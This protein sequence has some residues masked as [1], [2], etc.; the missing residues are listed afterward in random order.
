MGPD[1][2]QTERIG[3]RALQ[4]NALAIVRRVARGRRIMVTDG[5]RPVAQLVP[6]NGPR[7]PVRPDDPGPKPEAGD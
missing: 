2:T 3:I 6:L 7:S 1:T 4:V 5:G